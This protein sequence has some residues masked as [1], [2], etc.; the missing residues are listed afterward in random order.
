MF[1]TSFLLRWSHPMGEFVAFEFN[2]CALV[3]DD[4]SI[5]S[6]FSVAAR[7]N[8]EWLHFNKI[9]FSSLHWQ[10]LADDNAF[11]TRQQCVLFILL[12][13]LSN[14][15]KI[16]FFRFSFLSALFRYFH[17]TVCEVY[18]K[19]THYRNFSKIPLQVSLLCYL[20]FM[21]LP[22]VEMRF[23]CL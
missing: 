3:N 7:V 16:R 20:N 1:F 22:N 14:N 18:V 8:A 4:N 9:H 12:F 10:S 17:L 15:R 5:S 2:Q 6:S 11:A 19:S 23:G 13:C 21:H